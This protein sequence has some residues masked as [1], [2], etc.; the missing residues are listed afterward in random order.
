MLI[1]SA[2][3][4][5]SSGAVVRRTVHRTRGQ[6]PTQ[7]PSRSTGMQ[8]VALLLRASGRQCRWRML[9]AADPTRALRQREPLA[10]P[11]AQLHT[12]GGSQQGPSASF[13]LLSVGCSPALAQ[14]RRRSTIYDTLDAPQ[15]QCSRCVWACGSCPPPST[16]SMRASRSFRACLLGT[17][18]FGLHSSPVP[19]GQSATPAT[20][21]GSRRSPTHCAIRLASL[22]ASFWLEC[23]RL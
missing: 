17:R 12:A 8:V 10:P 15:R 6:A 23:T 19:S 9:S 14:R 11:R 13:W 7:A 1:R 22:G 5:T 20:C 3:S 4:S 16:S 2:V 18:Q 21:W